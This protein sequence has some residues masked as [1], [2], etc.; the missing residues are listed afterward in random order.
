MYSTLDPPFAGA[1]PD[2]S[3][4]V[5][6]LDGRRSNAAR[7]TTRGLD[8]ALRGA[9]ET[10]FGTWRFDVAANYVFEWKTAPTRNAP[11]V[12]SVDRIFNPL[13]K[14]ATAKLTWLRD[15]W[16]ASITS[17]YTGSYQNDTRGALPQGMRVDDHLVHDVLVAYAL[18][19][20]FG[21]ALNDVRLSLGVQNLF[22]TAPPLALNTN[23]LFDPQ[24]A[25]AIG[26]YWSI[27]VSKYW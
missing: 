11:L 18:D 26:R 2:P 12:D 21:A 1:A 27:G 23:I 25:S 4:V 9:W 6:V 22:D 5:A 13:S 14:Q 7:L 16:T 20:R 3:S 8:L 24:Y 10:R 17:R 19:D 15:P